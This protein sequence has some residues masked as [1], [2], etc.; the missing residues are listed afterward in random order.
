MISSLLVEAAIRSVLLALAVWI[1]L[2][3]FRVRNV[4]AQKAAWGVVLVAALAMPVVLPMASHWSVLPANVRVVIPADPQTLLEELQARIHATPSQELKPSADAAPAEGGAAPDHSTAGRL[5][6]SERAGNPAAAPLEA[7]SYEP[8]DVESVRPQPEPQHTAELAPVAAPQF[9]AASILTDALLV[10][11]A[12]A[13]VLLVRLIC[14]LMMAL[15]VW[16]TAKPISGDS[17]SSVAGCVDLACNGEVRCSAAVASPVT[18]C[19]VVVLPE[20]Y[21]TWDSEKLRVV[22]A[23]ERSHIR[24]GDFYLQLFAGIY[25][26]VVWFS[27][28]G[29]WLKRKLSDL[30]EA[31]SDRA[32]LEEAADRT[33]YAQILLEFA[34]A[35]RPTLIGVAMARNGSISRRIE[36]LLNDVSFRQAFGGTRR[37][38]LAVVVIPI[39]LF[40]ATALVHVEAAGQDT[41]PNSPQAVLPVTGVVS[42]D[43]APVQAG[44]QSQPRETPE[45]PATPAAPASAAAPASPDVAPVAPSSGVLA[46]KQVPQAPGAPDVAPVAPPH[47]PA[48]CPNRID[49]AP[50]PPA[51]A[52]KAPAAPRV[53]ILPGTPGHSM[54]LVAPKAGGMSRMIV[55]PRIAG[56][57]NH[58]ML[59]LIAPGAVF[60]DGR[61]IGIGQSSTTES[62]TSSHSENGK[63]SGSHYWYSTNGDS[64]AVVHGNDTEHMSFSGNWIAGRREEIEKARK[65]TGGK[66]FL[67][68]TRDS[69]SYFIDDP[70][71]LAQIEAM[72]KPM[73]ELGRQQEELGKKQEALGKQQEELGRQQEAASVPTPD[74]SKQIAEIDEAMA[75]LKAS[76][77]KNMTQEQ[78]AD[79]QEKLGDLQGKLGEIQGQIG[80]KQG[81]FGARMGALGG[82]MGE[83][84]AQQGRLG[85]AQGRLAQEADQ[86]VKSII[87]ESLK[88]G[89]AKPVQ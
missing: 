12:V 38:L 33:S 81:E 9:A 42:P 75:K 51:H 27:P 55:L 14:G 18:I 28:L 83:L 45:Q 22:L 16:R 89:K 50:A 67:W 24:Q 47:T 32:G 7:D 8:D 87:D 43:I 56:V 23:H 15:R 74:M 35:P 3:V 69:K 52:P 44:G 48:N 46:P 72:Y 41:E 30:A 29:W 61:G 73:E 13:G 54:T 26:A 70:S 63:R 78:F 2:R 10:Y 86:K 59:A 77:G 66:D 36:R 37:A 53:M 88:N 58:A 21:R 39:A 57:P 11:L 25:A 5:V 79:I 65:Q 60:G 82:K 40:A 68:F 71:T 62:G 19:S 85:A 80:S 20:N 6:V 4:A 76:Q 1:S 64:Y 34:A 84:G 17:L 49:L 31:I